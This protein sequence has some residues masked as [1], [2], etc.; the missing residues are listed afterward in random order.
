MIKN[1]FKVA[2]RNIIKHKG[3]S[4]INI[5]GLAIGIA[6]C[7]LIF[8]Y[9]K[10]ELTYDRYHKNE[11]R[12][13]R[14][15]STL[16]FAGNESTIGGSN[17]PEAMA[18]LESI[19]EI[20]SVVRLDNDAAIVTKG[21]DYI[22]Q[23]GLLYTDEALFNIFDFK[24]IDGAFEGSLKE[25]NNIVVTKDMAI[26]YFGKENVAG[27]SLEINI[28]NQ[29]ESY[30]ITAVVD[31]HPSNSSFNFKI[32]LPWAKRESQLNEYSLN[33]WSNISL[34][35]YVLLKEGVDKDLVVSKMRDVRQRRNPG[36]E[37]EFARGITNELQALKDV[38][39]DTEVGGGDGINDS[40]DASYSFILSGI[41]LIILIVA[42]INFANL[43][44]ARSLPRAREIGVRKV[45]GAKSKQ[46][47]FQFLNEAI[48]MCLIA[49][50]LGMILAE[51]ALPIFGTLTEKTFY[52]GVINDPN[53]IISCLGLVLLTAFLSGFYP[54]FVVSRFN[55]IK[56][57]KGKI[58]LKGNGIVSKILVVVQFTIATVLIVGTIAMNRQISFMVNM[59]LGYDDANLMKITSYGSGTKN[60]SQLFK[61]ELAQNPNIIKVAAADDYN[62]NMGAK[63]ND[64]EFVTTFNDMD[65]DYLDLIDGQLINGEVLKKNNALYINDQDT[66]YN[67]LVNEAFVKKSQLEDP[68]N[69]TFG[70]NR[71]V[72]VV[73]DY[74]YQ[75]VKGSVMPLMLVP[76]D[77]TGKDEFATIY[78]KYKPE[79][80]PLIKGELEATWREFVP[81]KPFISEFVEEANANRYRDEACWRTIIT[82]ASFLAILISAL[83]LFGLAHLT[84][85]QRVKEIGIRKV[86]GASLSQIV[87]LLNTNFSK[88]VIISIL[89]AS[90][91][92][93]FTIGHWLQN[94]ENIIR[95]TPFLILLPGLI[96]FL[97]AFL[98]VSF[99]SLK[100]VNA[101]PVDSLR[102]E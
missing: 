26:K 52:H 80:L 86:L 78:V 19:P 39:L 46:L 3:Y 28:K 45:L 87:I 65:D 102:N 29:R 84:T 59:D 41:A 77:E 23:T 37:G 95:I 18:Y 92:A 55:T 17:F 89:V 90:P 47:A 43:S 76:A 91:I 12:I 64:V 38:H 97:I 10:D 49:F 58:S 94:F 88:L 24:L 83:G 81:F 16:S 36:D 15:T 98:T 56:S 40:T 72:G 11:D 35:T 100:T 62:S 13:Y 4:V 48:M 42:C 53:L 85:Q 54:A 8:L 67:V 63:F 1:Y 93:Y 51:F 82:Y 32:V 14:I 101:N 22:S 66:L 6:C 57:L 74:Y 44:V 99:Q 20:E 30:Y 2:L 70:A 79:Y 27:Q 71:I 5:F 34:N 25:L 9:V 21:S 61:D 50:V 73:K 75:G 68:I 7:M 33:S 31:N 96:T 60:L 69:K